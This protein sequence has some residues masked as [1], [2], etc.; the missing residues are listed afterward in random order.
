MF[1]EVLGTIDCS[2]A[3]TKDIVLKGTTVEC[4]RMNDLECDG[5]VILSY[6]FTTFEPVFAMG[7]DIRGQMGCSGGRF[8][9][10]PLALNLERAKI[11]DAF[12]WRQIQGCWGILDLTNATIGTLVDDPD[13]WPREGKLCLDGLKYQH[14]ASNTSPN[15]FDR[16]GWLLCQVKPHLTYDFRPQ[17][18]EQLA[19]VLEKTGRSAEARQIRIEKLHFQRGANFLR[20]NPN[21][22]ALMGQRP[23]VRSGLQRALLE[24][25]IEI[26]QKSFFRDPIRELSAYFRWLSS[27]VFWM[28][29]G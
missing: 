26:E 10:H 27:C 6:G 23:F 22:V 4:L 16:L 11:G 28:I 5:S 13:S 20:R 15:Y 9:G 14:I 29:A 21:V 3:K 1:S 24:S 17:P 2:G 18:F 12:F 7:A 8:S 25:A 19:N